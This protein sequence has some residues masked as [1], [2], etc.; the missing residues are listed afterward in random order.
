MVE[1]SDPNL[2]KLLRAKIKLR[3]PYAG[4]FLRKDHLPSNEDSEVCTNLESLYEVGECD[5]CD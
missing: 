5:P 2:V 4:A 3:Q 1:V